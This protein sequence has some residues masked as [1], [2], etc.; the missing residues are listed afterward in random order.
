MTLTRDFRESVVARIRK[1]RAFRRSLLREGVE[2]LLSGDLEAGKSLL[3]DY[4]KATAGFPELAEATGIPA[5]SLIRMFGPTGNP[6]ARNLFLVVAHLQ[7]TEG[8][9]LRVRSAQAA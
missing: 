6:H 2:C 4:I 7:R 9:R 5:K 3:R 1:D 8:I